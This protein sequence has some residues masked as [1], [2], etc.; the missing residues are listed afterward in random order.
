MV[1]VLI[2]DDSASVRL[3]LQG[4]LAADPGIEV[5]GTAADGD[6]AVEAVARLNPDVVTMDI[7]MPRMNGLLATR[8]IMETHPVPIVVVS[9]NLDAEEVASTFRAIE[10]GAVTALPRPQ[11]P[12]HPNHEREARSFVQA[13]KLMA[14]VKVIKRW[15]RRDNPAS[16]PSLPC[17]A[18]VPARLKAVAIGASTGGPMVLQTILAGLRRDFPLP[19]LIVQHMAT[20]FIKG[21][22]EWLNLT[23]AL[24]VHIAGNGDRLIPGHA[25]VAPDCFHMLVTEDGT[26][27]ELQNTPPENGLRP[28]VSAL[29]RSVTQAFGAQT[30]GVLLTGMGS[31]GARELK[32]LREAGA[33]TIVQDR[34]SSVIHGMP[35]EALKLG[36]ATHT[37]P[38]D[39]IV[40]ALTSLAMEK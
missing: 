2:V 22:V 33:V 36:A 34:E 15:P 39:R 31:D 12:G 5:I 32:R 8:R 11:G 1:K 24:P 3:F 23:S 29:F 4:L 21:F 20:G 16:L 37:L 19:V 18:M 7:Y 38:P 28:S 9:G 26:A 30:V 40:T 27:I 25:Y 13:V 10:A 6:E 17:Q 35:G 14:E